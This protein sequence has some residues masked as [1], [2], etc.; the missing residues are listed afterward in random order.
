MAT[1]AVPYPDLPSH[2]T[3]WNDLF[4]RAAWLR[5]LAE[6]EAMQR[7]TRRLR[8]LK[9]TDEITLMALYGAMHRAEKE[10]KASLQALIAAGG[11]LYAWAPGGQVP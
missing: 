6:M 8:R 5:D 1:Q 11:L 4:W 9:G 2:T 3:P 10:T 7:L